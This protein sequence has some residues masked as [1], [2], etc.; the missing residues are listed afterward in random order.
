MACRGAAQCDPAWSALRQAPDNERDLGALGAWDRPGR[1]LRTPKVTLKSGLLRYLVRGSGR[2][3]A[4]VD[5]HLIVAGPLHGRVLLE[6]KGD[7]ERWQWVT[8]DL[9]PYAGH[10]VGVEFT[11]APA[12]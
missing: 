9:R 4:S 6:W 1:T 7:P 2:A 11:P 3:Y 8:H 10:R 12:E 5:S